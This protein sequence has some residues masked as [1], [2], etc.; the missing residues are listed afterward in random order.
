MLDKKADGFLKYTDED[1]LPRRINNLKE[2]P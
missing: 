2:L 1:F